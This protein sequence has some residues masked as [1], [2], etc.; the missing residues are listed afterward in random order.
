M[1]ERHALLTEFLRFAERINW[2]MTRVTLE[3]AQRRSAVRDAKAAMRLWT[4]E[5]A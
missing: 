1:R 5:N 3:L 4:E 2:P